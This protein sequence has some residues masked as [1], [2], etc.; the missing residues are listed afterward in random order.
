MAKEAYL[1]GKRGLLNDLLD[2][3]H[4]AHPH[5][6]AAVCASVQVS[7]ETYVYSKRG[8]SIWQK[9]PIY[10]AK[11]AYLYGKRGLLRSAHLSALI[12]IPSSI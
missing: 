2:H 8:L 9:C 1:Y 5:A 6:L 7:K 12:V 3:V 10:M 4:E 11:E